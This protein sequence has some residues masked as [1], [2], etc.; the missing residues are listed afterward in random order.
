MEV[1]AQEERSG[2]CGNAAKI[3]SV[4]A[5]VLLEVAICHGF[6]I[7]AMLKADELP[8][9]VGVFPLHVRADRPRLRGLVATVLR[10]R[11]R[12]LAGVRAHVAAEVAVVLRRVFAAVP[13]TSRGSFASVLAAVTRHGARVGAG[14]VAIL[15]L[16][17]PLLG[18]VIPHVAFEVT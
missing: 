7:A 18:V 14:V 17:G 1:V 13:G 3:Y 9:A 10:A 4:T 8:H 2:K 6:V 11:E 16:D 15:A 5:R 12:P